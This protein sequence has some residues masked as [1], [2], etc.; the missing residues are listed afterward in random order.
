MLTSR[1]AMQFCNLQ[2]PYF[3]VFG[4]ALND[5]SLSEANV[6]HEADSSAND[7]DDTGVRYDES[8]VSWSVSV[9]LT[10]Q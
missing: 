1:H 3:F 7:D 10:S 8:K 9:S 5:A 6:H 2:S 4:A